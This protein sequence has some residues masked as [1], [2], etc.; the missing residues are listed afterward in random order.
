MNKLK[1]LWL[2]ILN[3]LT[4]LA[5]CQVVRALRKNKGMFTNYQLVIA[6]CIE[7]ELNRQKE[8]LRVNQLDKKMIALRAAAIFLHTWIAPLPKKRAAR[9]QPE[10]QPVKESSGSSAPGK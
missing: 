3:I 1:T 8:H 10:T 4:Y 5:V 6:Q 9:K 7:Q 2:N